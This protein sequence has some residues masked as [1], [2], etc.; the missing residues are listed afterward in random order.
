MSDERKVQFSE[1][2]GGASG[3]YANHFQLFWTNVD[4][5]LAFG[6]LKH[7]RRDPDNNILTVEESAKITIPWSVAK[8]VMSS[9]MA[10]I[11]KYE[12][13]NGE[14]KLPGQYKLPAA[15]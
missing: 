12:Q 11:S 14:L 3:F 8:L 4:V 9:L 2:E 10:T 13:E 7:S 6:E 15:D 1:P 5:T